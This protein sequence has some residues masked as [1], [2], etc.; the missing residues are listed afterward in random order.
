MMFSNITGPKIR[1]TD[2]CI[3]YNNWEYHSLFGK[4]SFT[5]KAGTTNRKISYSM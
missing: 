2:N 5:E 4:F 3:D 1:I